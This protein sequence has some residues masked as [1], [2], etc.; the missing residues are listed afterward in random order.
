MSRAAA[1]IAVA[2]ALLL[3][4]GV[5]SALFFVD[6]DEVDDPVAIDSPAP[7]EEPVDPE[8]EPEP[9]A[10]DQP[11]DE[12]TA[13]PTPESTPEPPPEPD[14]DPSEEEAAED[15]DPGDDEADGEESDEDA[16]DEDGD[17]LALDDLPETG[18]G[19]PAA[20]AGLIALLGALGLIRRA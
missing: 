6:A 18:A 5:A 12:S 10:D 9:T 2:A 7:T 17:T 19:V 20:L 4:V 13:E 16:D 11:E 8:D 3:V 1:P 15:E 14:V